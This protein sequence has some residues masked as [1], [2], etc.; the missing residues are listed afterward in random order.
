MSEERDA[1]IKSLKQQVI[2]TLR[3]R[4][5]KGSF[6][7]FYRKPE[8]QTDLVMFQFSM[9]GSVLY[10]EVAK[11]SSEGYVDE[12]SDKL[13]PPKKVK[14]YQIGGGS[15]FNRTRIGKEMECAFEF[16]EHD[17]E[18]VSRKIIN[19]LVEA[20]EWWSTYPNWWNN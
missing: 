1:M 16:N 6:P 7:H 2:P 14:V 4:G 12:M 19:S 20:E 9:W 15:P 11:C 18:E 3:E 10:V 13:I 5:F 8:N 17:T